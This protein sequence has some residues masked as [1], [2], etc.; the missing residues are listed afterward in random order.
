MDFM[1]LLIIKSYIRLLF[2]IKTGLQ[3]LIDIILSDITVRIHL[4]RALTLTV[5]V[6]ESGFGQWKKGLVYFGYGTAYKVSLL[7]E[8]VQDVAL[9][10][11]FD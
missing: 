6:V 5:G 2:Q 3:Y 8:S 7:D 4:Y 10:E 1:K 11:A 9:L